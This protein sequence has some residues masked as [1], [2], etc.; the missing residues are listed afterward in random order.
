L[1]TAVQDE[2]T[3]DLLGRHLPQPRIPED[4][5]PQASAISS[6]PGSSLAGM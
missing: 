3:R 4:G 6:G 1:Q 5:L 2:L